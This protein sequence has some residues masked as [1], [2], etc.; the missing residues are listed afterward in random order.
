MQ[1][2]MYFLFGHVVKPRAILNHENHQ[3]DKEEVLLVSI[4]N[5]IILSVQTRSLDGNLIQNIK[6]LRAWQMIRQSGKCWIFDLKCQS[7]LVD[8]TSIS[9]TLGM[10]DLLHLRMTTTKNVALAALC[11]TKI[12]SIKLGELEHISTTSTHHN[13]K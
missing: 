8:G 5:N 10:Y 6:L 11:A 4:C 13:H 12:K 9:W 2:Q 1:L 3:S 7:K